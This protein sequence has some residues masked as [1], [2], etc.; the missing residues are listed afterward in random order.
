MEDVTNKVQVIYPS[1]A[2]EEVLVK[3]QVVYAP[4]VI[5]KAKRIAAIMGGK[6]EDYLEFIS[7][8]SMQSLNELIETLLNDT[9]VLKKYP[10]K[11]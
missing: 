1:L 10:S 3:T 9:E 4:L 2:I 8:F 7:A 5:E 11:N 6:P